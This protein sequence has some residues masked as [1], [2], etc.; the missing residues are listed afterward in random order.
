MI[1]DVS[2]NGC[3]TY[4]GIGLQT[5]LAFSADLLNTTF[6]FSVTWKTK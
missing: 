6:Y 5:D 3:L 4:R 2:E 1:W